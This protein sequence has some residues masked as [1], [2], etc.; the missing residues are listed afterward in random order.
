MARSLDL[1]VVAEGVET[2]A[3]VAALLGQDCPYVQG[4]LFSKP[5]APDAVDA[6]LAE[7]G[8]WDP[9]T[10]AAEVPTPVTSPR[11]QSLIDTITG[12][13]GAADG[14]L[15]EL[16]GTVAELTSLDS[17]YLTSINFREG[18][19]RILA[20]ANT[21][22]ITIEPGTR[23]LWDDTVC[24]RAIADARE[25]IEDVPAQYPEAHAAS[26]LGIRTYL[27][28][29]LHGAKGELLGTLCG[30]TGDVSRIPQ[31]TVETLHWVARLL[32]EHAVRREV[33]ARRR[34]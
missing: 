32:G 21:G 13:G 14:V 23:I 18:Y 9:P 22:P 10:I 25:V 19:Q 26:D 7:A 29:E 34:T 33:T 6:L 17:V 11:L 5:I 27:G 15:E 28:V 24:R 31:E 8:G 2:P 1:E 20:A 3:Q 12:E 16:L 30:V 4:Y